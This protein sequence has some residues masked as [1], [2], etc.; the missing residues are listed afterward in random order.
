MKLV[1]NR[2]NNAVVYSEA[3][4]MVAPGE[5]AYVDD[6]AHRKIGEA[7]AD[8]RLVEKPVPATMPTNVSDSAA[9]ALRAAIA[10][11][12]PAVAPKPEN[13]DE[14]KAKR[15]VRDTGQS[16]TTTKKKEA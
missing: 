11:R 13:D 7:L 9:E 14:S 5:F 10:D 12:T 1:Y 6:E 15:P 3:G 4:Q 8:G 16:R 2:T